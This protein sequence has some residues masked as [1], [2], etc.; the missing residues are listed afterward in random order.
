LLL[1]F[2]NFYGRFEPWSHGE[3]WMYVWRSTATI[4]PVANQIAHVRV[5]SAQ[6]SSD[7]SIGWL[8]PQ[9]EVMQGTW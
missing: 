3:W 4:H 7:P 8:Y 6:L 5:L 1:L 2:F 9:Q